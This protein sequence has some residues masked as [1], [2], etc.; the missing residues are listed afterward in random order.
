VAFAGNEGPWW[1]STSVRAVIRDGL[2][3]MWSEGPGG[4]HYENIRGPYMQV[5]C[6]VFV[7]GNEITVVQD[8]R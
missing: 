3:F 2:A 6:G 1:R 8:H 4:G 5:G 7:N